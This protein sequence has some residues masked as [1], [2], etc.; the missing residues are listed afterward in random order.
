M[1]CTGE[2]N[3]PGIKGLL[4]KPL[5]WAEQARCGKSGENM[6]QKFEVTGMTCA[7]CSAHVEKAVCKVAGVDQVNVNLLGNSMV[8]EYNKGQTDAGQ[9]IHAVEEAGYGAALSATKGTAAARPKAENV[10]EE[11]AAGM[12]RRFLTSLIFLVPLF[13]IAMGHMMGWPLP[14]FF[15]DPGNV[16]V[17]A[18]LQFLLT[19]PIMYIN[20]KYYR[21]GF[22]TLWHRSP[23]MDSLIALGSAA[24]VVYGVAALFQ[25]AWAWAT[26][27]RPGWISGPW[28]CTLSPQA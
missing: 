20:D 1:I 18:F 13:Y 15:H 10:M 19:L 25:I 11:E 12:K 22:K 27:I 9:I 6:K 17:M 4:R 28:I 2:V 16:F 23:N 21:V 8:V 5:G 3:S 24:A 14:A 26:A 7:A